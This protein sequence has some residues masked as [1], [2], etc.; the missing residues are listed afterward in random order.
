MKRFL[1]VLL[2][3][4]PAMVSAE[5]EQPP[6]V[7][8]DVE[9]GQNL[10]AIF[11][12]VSDLKGGD[13]AFTDITVNN[14]VTVGGAAY[15]FLPVGIVLPYASTTTI[16]SG[17][18]QCQGQSVSTTT[19]SRLFAVIGYAYGGMGANFNIPNMK[20]RAPIGIGQGNTAEGGTAG[21][22]WTIGTSTGTETHTLSQAELA[23]HAHAMWSGGTYT[24]VVGGASGIV[25]WAAGGGLTGY[26]TGATGGGGAHNNLSPALVLNYII[27]TGL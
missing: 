10:T 22:T 19:Y 20:G 13:S 7:V 4:I 26:V 8:D 1:A 6:Y 17:W 3:F 16:P 24:T 12:E 18:L 21:T 14:T 11:K 9:I 25:G 23:S 5:T 27:Y 2:L 15:N